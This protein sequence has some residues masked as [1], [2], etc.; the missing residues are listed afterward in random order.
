MCWKA[1]LRGKGEGGRRTGS[2]TDAAVRGD[3]DHALIFDLIWQFYC[4][5]CDGYN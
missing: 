1:E 2:S 5:P 3:V 4:V